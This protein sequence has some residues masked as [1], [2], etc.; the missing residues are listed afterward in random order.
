MN[1]VQ[2]Q[3]ILHNNNCVFPVA[4]AAACCRSEQDKATRR[5][6]H[7]ERWHFDG[8]E[9]NR[10]KSISKYVIKSSKFNTFT[11]FHTHTHTHFS[12]LNSICFVELYLL[13]ATLTAVDGTKEFQSR[14]SSFISA[15]AALLA[16][17]AAA[18]KRTTQ[19]APENFNWI[20]YL[21]NFLWTTHEWNQSLN[22]WSFCREPN[23]YEK[24]ERMS[25]KYIEIRDNDIKNSSWHD[26]IGWNLAMPLHLF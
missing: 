12:P 2:P 15:A 25:N 17:T 5:I 24:S 23:S 1:A 16:T 22:N 26:V 7:D 3:Q 20:R 10:H 18:T 11:R 4:G 14:N 9:D 19:H 13:A 8:I 6:A 21:Y